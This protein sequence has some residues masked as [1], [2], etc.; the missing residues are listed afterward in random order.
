L[1]ILPV[2]FIAAIENARVRKD[3]TMPESD[4]TRIQLCDIWEAVGLLTRLPAFGAGNRGVLAGWAWPLAGAIVALI[5]GIIGSIAEAIGMPDPMTA[6]LVIMVMVILTGAMHE[7]GLADCADGFWGGWTPETR[8]EIMKDSRIGTYGVAAL[9]LFLLFRWSA[10][11]ALLGTG[12][13]IGPLIATAALSRVPMLALLRFMTCAR[14]GGLSDKVGRPDS[15]TLILA[16]TL[17]MLLALLFSGFVALPAALLIIAVTWGAALL[18]QAKIGG[19]T[20]DI[21]GATQQLAE[22]AALAVF[23]SFLN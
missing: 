3:R 8:L 11:V 21:L 7:D 17:A 14:S 12:T 4:T 10:V 18:S 23:V 22:I 20:G 16:S 13:L 15:E 9:V 2:V 1:K 6:V 19:Q 5:A